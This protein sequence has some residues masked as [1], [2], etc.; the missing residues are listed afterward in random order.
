VGVID[1]IRADGLV[2]GIFL[3]TWGET[4]TRYPLGDTADP[5]SV[6][7]IVDMDDEDQGEPVRDRDGER[8]VRNCILEVTEREEIND[9]DTFHLP[10][11]DGGDALKWRV[12][13][14]GKGRD[15]GMKSVELT[16]LEPIATSRFT[17]SRR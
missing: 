8:I 11:Y 6:L 5:R 2:G 9:R 12:R 17:P 10:N 14:I 3:R 15:P 16:R 1:R 4:V 7:A 13:R